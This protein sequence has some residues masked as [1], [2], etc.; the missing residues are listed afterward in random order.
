M[1]IIYKA[2]FQTVCRYKR[3]ASNCKDLT[4]GYNHSYINPVQ[5]DDYS[6]GSFKAQ[7]QCTGM[8][9]SKI[10]ELKEDLIHKAVFLLILEE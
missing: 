1:P 6:I 8:R 3:D 5:F 2:P 9:R 4:V 7:G 10:K